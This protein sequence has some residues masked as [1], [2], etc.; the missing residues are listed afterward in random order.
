[1]V[2]GEEVGGDD[3]VGYG[4]FLGWIKV[5]G[6]GYVLVWSERHCGECALYCKCEVLFC[7]IAKKVI[8][9]FFVSKLL[10]F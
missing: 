6:W 7:F 2:K 4:K 5:F 8:L 9:I 10:L 1:M 3:R